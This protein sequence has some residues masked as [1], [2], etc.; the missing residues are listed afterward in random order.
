M[1]K[2]LLLLIAFV[3]TLTAKGSHILGSDIRYEYTGSN[4]RLELTVYQSCGGVAATDSSLVNIQSALC[5]INISDWLPLYRIDT[6]D[7]VLCQLPGTGCGTN[8]ALLI[9]YHYSDTISLSS[10]SD[11]KISYTNGSRGVLDNIMNAPTYNLYVEAFLDNSTAPNSSPV[12]GGDPPVVSSVSSLMHHYCQALDIEG[13][14]LS[15][16]M[17]VPQ[18]SATMNLTYALGYSG[19]APMGAGGAAAL[20]TTNGLL[21]LNAANTGKYGLAMRIYDYRNGAIVGYSSRDWAVSILPA[22]AVTPPVPGPANSFIT[23]A[24]PGGA[25]SI[26]LSF[27]DSTATDSVFLL[28]Q[29]QNAFPY[30]ITY[31][32][33][34]GIAT[35]NISWVNP[36]TLNPVTTPYFFLKVLAYNHTCPLKGATWYTILVKTAQCNTDSVWAGDANGDYTVTLYDPLAVALAYGKTGP[37]RTGASTAWAAQYCTPWAWS[38]NNNVNYKHADCDG[39][40][41]VDNADLTAIT[42]NYGQFHLKEGQAPYKGTGV[43]SLYFDHTGINASPGA[44]VTVP[45]KLGSAAQMM[46]NIYGLAAQ[47]RVAGITPGAPAISYP[48]SWIGTATGTVRFSRI[49]GSN[50]IDWA[51]ARNNQ[52]NVS[53]QGTIAALS[54]TIPSGTP[55]GQQIVLSLQQARLINAAGATIT[56]FNALADTLHVVPTNVGTVTTASFNAVIVPNPATH[57]VLYLSAPSKNMPVS[58][59][60]TDIAGRM[61]WKTD[62]GLNGATEI[63]LPNALM[64]GVYFVRISDGTAVATIKW[65]KSE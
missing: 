37:A 42:A 23:T 19:A 8:N 46:N 54:F 32:N 16:Q 58:V 53:G 49:T 3:V 63:A 33:G 45:I 64:N 44:T 62:R 9:A 10:C 5:S 22:S 2:S 17:I 38:F 56:D 43:P 28:V 31:A 60:I 13:D 6:L 57:A 65:M 34:V 29:P 21:S 14:S 59:H 26:N 18:Q 35:A 1:K 15:Y 25:S 36:N 39:N 12:F 55:A 47:I 4:Y 24:C 52:Q 20:N 7:D 30:T 61:V 48:V 27:I 41:I 50:T 11:W 40:G 51:Y